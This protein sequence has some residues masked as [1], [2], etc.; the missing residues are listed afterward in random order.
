LEGHDT[1]VKKAIT[2]LLIEDTTEYAEL[3]QRWLSGKSDITFVLNWTDSLKAGIDRLARGGVDVIL[4]DLGLPDSQGLGTFTTT[5][6]HAGGVPIILLSGS[7]TES[8]ALEMMRE[9]AQDYIVKSSCTAE[10]LVKAIQYAVLRSSSHAAKTGMDATAIGVIGAAGGVGTSTVACSLALELR[11]QTNQAVLLADMD[12][13]AGLV[14]FLMNTKSE[15]T[16][17]DAATNVGRLDISFWEGMV[18]EGPEG[19]QI[20]GSPGLL[21]TAEADADKLRDVL[22]IVRAF[23]RW[24]VVDLGQLTTLSM[25]LMDRV[26][27]LFLVTTTSLPALFEARRAVTALMKAGIEADR[28]RLVVNQDEDPGYN[29][30]ELS[31]MLGIPVFAR[32]PDVARELD[33][34]CAQG[35]FFPKTGDFREHIAILARKV[36]GLPELKQKSKVAKFLSFGNKPRQ[37]GATPSNGTAARK[38]PA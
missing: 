19:L 28:L 32:L 1:L 24:I 35:R 8:L 22:T 2:V 3:V 30:A 13:N 38:V 12:V 29:G 36:A 17:L 16:I 11:S 37:A 21:G 9:G 6:A 7:D 5:R 31:R 34:A 26:N 27:E 10:V 25:S 18:A 14:S 23:Y 20:V 33:E 4:L 15:Y